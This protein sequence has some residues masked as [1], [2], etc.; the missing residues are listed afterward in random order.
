MKRAI[1]QIVWV[2]GVTILLL[3]VPRLGGFVA[4]QF[5]YTA[6][7]PDHTFA[8]ISV[9]HIAQALI[10]LALMVAL[11]RVRS[12][13]F[14]FGCGDRKV[15]F[16]FVRIFALIFASY[17]V[18]STVIVL[19]FGT[20]RT[21]PYPLTARNVAG[22]LAFQLLLSGS[23]EELIFRAFAITMLAFATKRTVLNGRVTVATL[24][25][26]VIFGFAH[27]GI[28]LSPFALTADPFQVVYA[29]ALGIA[30][31]ICYERSKSVYYPMMMHSIS[32]V[33]AVGVSVV[34]TAIIG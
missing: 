21:F 30:Y 19:V 9:H 32:N 24:I 22:Q 5:D 1:A 8:W 2:I 27:V 13:D 33:I 11:A 28:S 10:L 4:D 34:A 16:R 17:V 14:G 23:S 12:V 3:G 25:A 31:G 20:F 29:T 18:V 7:D 6:I 15:G 26:A